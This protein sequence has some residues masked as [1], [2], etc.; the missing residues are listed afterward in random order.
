MEIINL[1]YY[2]CKEF[3]DPLFEKKGIPSTNQKKMLQLS[4]RLSKLEVIHL[5]D[6][7]R[8]S[9]CL[10]WEVAN[11]KKHLMSHSQNLLLEKM[12]CIC[13]MFGLLSMYLYLVFKYNKRIG[14]Y[15]C[16]FYEWCIDC[17]YMHFSEA[18][19]VMYKWDILYTILSLDEAIF[20][21][22]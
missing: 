3:V 9:Q 21:A 18:V 14:V 17:V 11:L 22:K 10:W 6:P 4:L 13:Q 2:K 20:C 19:H 7:K 1:S 12:Y 8:Y 16:I 15:M 5:K